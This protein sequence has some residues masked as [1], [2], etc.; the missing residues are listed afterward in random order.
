ML[1]V[2]YNAESILD[3]QG[4]ESSEIY[5]AIEK[6]SLIDNICLC[7]TFHISTIP[8]AARLL[9]SRHYQ[10][11]L[12]AVP[13]IRTYKNGDQSIS[14]DDILE[15]LEFHQLSISLLATVAYQNK[16]GIDRLTRE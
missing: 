2:L 16:W 13:F 8:L 14:V 7:I 5:S 6:L 4:P 3:P 1:I 9:K 10:W 15:Q 11:K 12:H